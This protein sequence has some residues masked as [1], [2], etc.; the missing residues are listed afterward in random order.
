MHKRTV[1][2]NLVLCVNQRLLQTSASAC[3]RRVSVERIGR[4]PSASTGA[5]VEIRVSGQCAVIEWSVCVS[6]TKLSTLQKER[7]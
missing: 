6:V 1:K 4:M 3:L 2:L 7:R 5:N